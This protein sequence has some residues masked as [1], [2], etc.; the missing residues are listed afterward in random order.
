MRRARVAKLRLSRQP[1]PHARRPLLG[2]SFTGISGVGFLL[3]D[4]TLNPVASNPEAVQILTYPGKPEAMP[5]LAAFLADKIRRCL[6]S[7]QGYPSP[8]VTEF[9]SGN[10][11]YLCRAFLLDPH[12]ERPSEPSVALVLERNLS[13]PTTLYRISEQFHFTPR[14]RQA[15]ELLLH[16]LTNKEIA[17]RMVISL[18][19]VKFLFRLVMLKLGVSSRAEIIARV[20]AGKSA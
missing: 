7:P 3:T 12:G 14:Q 16:G 9:K 17:D 4:S 19:T 18:H 6:V 20:I 15:V 13:G 11:R 2:K 8:F 5:R 1:K 10:R